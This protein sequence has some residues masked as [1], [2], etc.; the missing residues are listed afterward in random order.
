V[1]KAA[2]LQLVLTRNHIVNLRLGRCQLQ[3]STSQHFSP[4]SGLVV[5]RFFSYLIGAFSA[6]MLFVGRQEDHPA[7][8]KLSDGVLAW[9]SFWG[10]V[11]MGKGDRLPVRLVCKGS[12]RPTRFR[13]HIK[14]PL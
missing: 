8:K 5:D 12:S 6:L 2:G 10:E 14:S 9:L 7:Y 11:Q 1:C 4:T 3:M 13:G